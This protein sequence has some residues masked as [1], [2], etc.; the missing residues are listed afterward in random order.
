[1]VGLPPPPLTHG[2]CPPCWLSTDFRLPL[3]NGFF[4]SAPA[5]SHQDFP[6]RMTNWTQQIQGASQL[7]G[8]AQTESAMLKGWPNKDGHHLEI[9]WLELR[10]PKCCEI[11]WQLSTTVRVAVKCTCLSCRIVGVYERKEPCEEGRAG[12]FTH[13]VSYTTWMFV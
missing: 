7:D 10:V 11:L 6:G 5:I 4:S 13:M 8:G 3:S 2:S 1:M 9:T 12:K